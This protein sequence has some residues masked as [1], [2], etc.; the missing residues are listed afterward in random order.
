MAD[1]RSV[2]DLSIEE[3]ERVLA[4]R[5]RQSRQQQMQRMKSSGRIVSKPSSNKVTPPSASKPEQQQEDA[6]FALPF[7]PG[8]ESPS[9]NTPQSTEQK[10]LK[11]VQQSTPVVS[12]MKS[13]SA[14]RFDDDVDELDD[15]LH[16]DRDDIWRAFVNRF[17]LLI[18]VAAVIGI[19]FIGVQMVSSINTLQDETDAAQD[20]A[21][22]Q[23]LAS[24]PTPAPTPTVRLN[25]VV[26]P[27]GHV[28]VESGESYFNYDEVPE[29]LRPRFVSE[30]ERPQIARPAP[31]DE[32]PFQIFIPSLGIEQTI[33]QGVDWDAL[34]QGVGQV[35]NGATPG[36]LGN[37]VVLAAHNDI[38]GQIF[39]H[40]ED[41][42]VGEQFQIRTVSGRTYTYE[43][44]GSDIVQ[45][46]AVH[47]MENVSGEATAT[48]ISC[49]PY[50]VNDR[51]IVIFARQINT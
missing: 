48:L 24:V 37:N 28:Y 42:A 40:L 12:P 18:E 49:Y 35:Q 21:N 19:L 31:T 30:I 7:E 43:I 11:P 10:I 5:K 45:P 17:L 15:I 3:L 41:L 13:A 34:R 2:D 36:Q 6:P 23:R 33:I 29:Q 50:Q 25:D 38:Y 22:Q 46:D 47:V 51:R 1:K 8:K 27:S 44:T 20:M 4:I 9:T 39:R 14:V 16:R 32:T 26:L